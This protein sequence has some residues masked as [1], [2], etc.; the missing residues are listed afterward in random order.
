MEEPSSEQDT[1]DAPEADSGATTVAAAAHV[2][3]DWWFKRELNAKLAEDLMRPSNYVGALADILRRLPE[4]V[5]VLKVENVLNAA[6]AARF[7][8]T[9]LLYESIYSGETAAYTPLALFHGTRES[10]VRSIGVCPA[11]LGCGCRYQILEMSVQSCF[12]VHYLFA[13]DAALTLNTSTSVEWL[14]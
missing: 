10:N 3:K 5:G 1:S 2:R 8:E 6:A 13:F 9:K 4:Q 14:V 11:P 7:V 12:G